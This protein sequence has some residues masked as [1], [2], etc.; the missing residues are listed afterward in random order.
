MPEHFLDRVG[1]VF[2]IS[3]TENE[4]KRDEYHRLHEYLK[5]KEI[6]V[7]QRIEKAESAKRS[8]EAKSTGLPSGKIPAREF[9]DKRQQK[10][11]TLSGLMTH[12]QHSLDNVTHAKSRAYSKYLEYK[13]KAEAEEREAA[14]GKK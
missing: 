6:Q 5:S 11:D 12:F 13:A 8:Y 10:D 14:A 7:R 1:N 3:Y 9:E 4:R 2:H